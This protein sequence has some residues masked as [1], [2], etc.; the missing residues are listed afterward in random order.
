MISFDQIPADEME[1]MCT[2][3]HRVLSPTDFPSQ[4]QTANENKN[5]APNPT[6]GT[7]YL[8]SLA[9]AC[10]PSLLREHGITHLVQVLDGPSLPTEEANDDASLPP[11][12]YFRIDIEDASDAAPRLRA[13][14]TPACDYIRDA[15][16]GGGNVLV[17]C[18]Q[19]V[20][21]SASVVIAFLIRDRGMG[22]VAARAFVRARRRCVRPNAGFEAV[23]REWQ[24]VC[25]AEEGEGGR[26]V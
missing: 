25:R 8:G 19:G 4:T 22:Y 7:L 24:G 2:P 20:S 17:H 5:K 13:E 3:M 16:A 10:E 1:A 12:A 23:L 26:G 14:L 18:H 11:F 15:L 9:A 6:P 21:R